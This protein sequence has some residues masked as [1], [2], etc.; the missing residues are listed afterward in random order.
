M[1]FRHPAGRHV[2]QQVCVCGVA[3]VG[4]LLSSCHPSKLLILQSA[5]ARAGTDR[6]FS[7][8]QLGRVTGGL[9]T[10]ESV[11]KTHCGVITSPRN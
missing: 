1:I 5:S 8:Q 6:T 3:Q 2:T 10:G 11:A 9:H 7:D 4:V